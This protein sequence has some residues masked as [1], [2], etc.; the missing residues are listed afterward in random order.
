MHR[1][2]QT[3]L[4]AKRI[5]TRAGTKWVVPDKWDRKVSVLGLSEIDRQWIL[6]AI[7]YALHDAAQTGYYPREGEERYLGWLSSH[8][9]MGVVRMGQAKWGTPSRPQKY[10]SSARGHPRLPLLARNP[11]ALLPP[12]F[13]GKDLPRQ[14]SI[15][16]R[17][18]L[19]E[20]MAPG[21]FVPSH[22]IIRRLVAIVARELGHQ[23]TSR[24]TD[25]CVEA[26]RASTVLA[27]HGFRFTAKALRAVIDYYDVGYPTQRKRLNGYRVSA[28]RVGRIVEYMQL[29]DGLWLNNLVWAPG[30]HV[31]RVK[32]LPPGIEWAPEKPDWRRQRVVT[33][34][35]APDRFAPEIPGEEIEEEPW[36]DIPDIT[37]HHDDPTDWE[38]WPEPPQPEPDW[39]DAPPGWGTL[40]PKP[41]RT[42]TDNREASKGSSL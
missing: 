34:D 21:L 26:Y 30:K 12:A 24:E 42:Q 39:N 10:R 4:S 40:T 36:E 35:P 11:L 6:E 14:V 15:F 41:I 1:H 5:K 16:M 23:T 20:L 25:E 32:P 31:L 17:R 28:Y 3:R 7:Q 37:F 29:P 13:W 19:R 18:K 22:Y 33:L 8:L 2:P 27:F 9:L 38:D